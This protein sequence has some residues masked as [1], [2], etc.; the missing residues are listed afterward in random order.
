M[1]GR[2]GRDKD[3]VQGARLAGFGG[4]SEENRIRIRNLQ[5]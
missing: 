4:E 5:N 2:P 1:G 3:M